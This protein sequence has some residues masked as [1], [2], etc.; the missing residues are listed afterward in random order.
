MNYGLDNW[1]SN[2]INY[3]FSAKSNILTT[4]YKKRDRERDHYKLQ[5]LRDQILLCLQGH[6]NTLV[7]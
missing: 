1:E 7:N 2:R 3:S 5:Q 4:F 6:S